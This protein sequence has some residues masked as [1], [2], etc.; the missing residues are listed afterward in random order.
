MIL[1]SANGKPPLVLVPKITKVL[2]SAKN[3]KNAVGKIDKDK[4]NFRNFLLN[5]VLYLF[6]VGTGST[7]LRTSCALPKV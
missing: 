6:S 3:G 2:L 4:K 7:T 1:L 5:Q